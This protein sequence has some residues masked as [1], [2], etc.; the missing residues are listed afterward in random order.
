MEDDAELE[1]IGKEYGAGRMK[2]REVCVCVTFTLLARF[3]WATTPIF[4]V[5]ST[6]EGDSNKSSGENHGPASY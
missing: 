1:R 6:G 4:S 5:G 3:M 2:T